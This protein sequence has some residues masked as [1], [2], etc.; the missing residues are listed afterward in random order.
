[1][2]TNIQCFEIY[3]YYLQL[4]WK[5]Q[6]FQT[7]C[8]YYYLLYKWIVQRQTVTIQSSTK[9]SWQQ[10]CTHVVMVANWCLSVWCHTPHGL[11]EMAQ[12]LQSNTSI[13]D[14][15]I[16]SNSMISY[17]FESLNY[18]DDD[19]QHIPTHCT[20]V[21]FFLLKEGTACLAKVMECIANQNHCAD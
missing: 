13:T 19:T 18:N 21:S 10:I 2:D 1:M 20:Y 7:T 16:E 15:H 5:L 6:I 9:L 17:T 12:V 11:L 3:S 4:Y 14:L 8:T